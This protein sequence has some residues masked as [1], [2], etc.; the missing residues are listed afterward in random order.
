MGKR[1]G[2]L[3]V[4]RTVGL[5]V[6]KTN[7]ELTEEANVDD[8]KEERKPLG[9]Q[10]PQEILDRCKA[11]VFPSDTAFNGKDV[12]VIKLGKKN[13]VAA[14]TWEKDGVVYHW[15]YLFLTDGQVRK[16]R[17]TLNGVEV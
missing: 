3:A 7:L 17:D 1:A 8:A 5:F 12:R 14:A 16:L 2:A 4:D 11:L 13:Y 15:S 10:T 9:P 6:K